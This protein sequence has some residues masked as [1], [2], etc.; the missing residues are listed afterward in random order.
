MNENISHF[1]WSENSGYW[2]AHQSDW[3]W[4]LANYW[5]N[6][7]EAE[8]YADQHE[9]NYRAYDECPVYIGTLI[10]TNDNQAQFYPTYVRTE[11][12]RVIPEIMYAMKMGTELPL[13]T[14]LTEISITNKHISYAEQHIPQLGSL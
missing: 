14:L 4:H 6:E 8:A 3:Q 13:R 2:I 5:L 9:N 11:L 10:T 12:E 1:Y 7:K